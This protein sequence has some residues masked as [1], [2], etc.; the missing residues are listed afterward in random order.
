MTPSIVIHRTVDRCPD[1]IQTQIDSAWDTLC[2]G[3]PRY[4]N[5]PILCF[6]SYDDATGVIRATLEEYKNH[7]VRDSINLNH[8]LLAVTGV[9]QARGREGQTM[10]FVGKRSPSTHRYGHLWEFG[11][12]GGID[13]PD[14]D[15]MTV[16]DIIAELGR[17]TLEEAGFVMGSA[18]ASPIALVHDDRVGSTDIVLR[19]TLPSIPE[20]ST[21]WEYSDA[22]WIEHDEL[23]KWMARR[24][25]DFIPT[26]RPIMSLLDDPG[27][28][29]IR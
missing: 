9:L 20:M 19:V 12:C 13:V 3:N 2:A 29:I 4:F 11:P 14:S 6:G 16:D 25:N 24:P 8:S 10:Y 26:A 17:E 21:G 27:A 22:R 23:F 1:E 15:H 7:A 18:E 5:A 28:T